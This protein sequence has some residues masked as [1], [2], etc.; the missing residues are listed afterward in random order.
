MRRQDQRARCVLGYTV[1]VATFLCVLLAST[2]V[3]YA[4][5]W[6][7]QVVG[8]GADPSH[9]RV[10]VTFTVQPTINCGDACD[11]VIG[12]F[13]GRV[14]PAPPGQSIFGP[15]CLESLAID[16]SGANFT[17]PC[18]GVPGIS[19]GYF[20]IDLEPSIGYVFSGSYAGTWLEGGCQGGACCPDDFCSGSDT[21][22]AALDIPQ[23][24][25]PV[26]AILLSRL[27]ARF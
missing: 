19:D 8:P 27:K 14:M 24:P 6:L 22:F 18:A 21:D 26:R 12:S 23:N 20:E 10:R 7:F 2:S 17:T 11:Y 5:D 1:L 4:G 25:V 9:V 16:E 3:V 15:G 13:S